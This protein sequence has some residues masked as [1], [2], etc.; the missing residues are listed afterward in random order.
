MTAV[1]ARPGR[2]AGTR[3]GLPLLIGHQFHA[4]L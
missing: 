1:T 2:A 3:R 4:D